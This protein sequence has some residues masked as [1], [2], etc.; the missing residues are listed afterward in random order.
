MAIS[1]EL[2][3]A[4]I[5]FLMTIFIL[6]YLI[7]DNP[8]FRAAIYVFV[9]ISAGYVAAVAW[10]QVLFPLL[11]EPIWTGAVFSNPAQ[12]ILLFFPL[13]GSAF[14]LTKV[15]PRLGG[16][17][18]LPMAY[19]VGIGAGVTIGGAVLGTLIP[20]I[21]STFEAF[22]LELAAASGRNL[23][24]T[25][26]N[27]SIMLL[28][29]IG[30]LAYFHFGARLHSDGSVRRNVFINI[31]TWVGRIYIAI[32]FGVLFAGVYS[33]ALTALIERI[34]SMRIF[35]NQITLSL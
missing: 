14:L 18:H 15:S 13:I 31:L 6:S 9:G 8:L 25:T 23:L 17:G 5:S 3:S 35:F 22:D 21:N 26:V 11:I 1:S 30:T 12:A 2:L 19:L 29:V 7:R 33:A 34:D 24:L 20:Q 32:T 10:R 27:S 28:G 16:L 4:I